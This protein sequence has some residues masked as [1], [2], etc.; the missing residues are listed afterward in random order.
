MCSETL[1]AL[2][3]A[4]VDES[5]FL[6][7]AEA[8]SRISPLSQRTASRLLPVDGWENQELGAFLEASVAWAR[9]SD[10][11]A[12][13]GPKPANPWALFAAF[14]WAGRSYE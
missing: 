11:G 8:L 9:D 10:F 13:P 2:L 1:L 4:V 5:T 7:F 3:E 14:L 12:R 6:R